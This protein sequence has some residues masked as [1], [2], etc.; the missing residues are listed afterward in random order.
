MSKGRKKVVNGFCASRWHPYVEIWRYLSNVSV[1]PAI[2]QRPPLFLLLLLL[3]MLLPLLRSPSILTSHAGNVPTKIYS[4]ML[5]WI[6]RPNRPSDSPVPHVATLV[7]T[8][9]RGKQTP[10][11]LAESRTPNLPR[12]SS[13]LSPRL[14]Q[15][16]TSSITQ[17]NPSD[18]SASTSKFRSVGPSH[19]REKA[20][21]NEGI[22]RQQSRGARRMYKTIDE[23]RTDGTDRSS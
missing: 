3:L 2:F 6:P 12:P 1:Q 22:R 5:R 7:D 14:L 21:G 11:A 20:K 10:I 8:L 15:S 9:Q 16:S 19:E 18:T 4:G 23:I 17:Q 13:Q